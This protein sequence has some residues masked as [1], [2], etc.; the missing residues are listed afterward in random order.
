[1]KV[2]TVYWMAWPLIIF[3][4]GIGSK[5]VGLQKNKHLSMSLA[6]RPSS[7]LGG[8][9]QTSM[10][11][12]ELPIWSFETRLKIVWFQRKLYFKNPISRFTEKIC[13]QSCKFAIVVSQILKPSDSLFVNLQILQ[14]TILGCLVSKP[15]WPL[16]LGGWAC[17]LK[18]PI[19]FNSCPSIGRGRQEAL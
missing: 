14:F 15:G 9:T 1:M 19:S 5:G 6:F 16:I 8:Q 4:C 3:V 12:Q 18:C 13:V 7:A 17:Q 10:P 2:C 11:L